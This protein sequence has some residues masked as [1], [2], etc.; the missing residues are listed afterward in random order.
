MDG[1]ILTGWRTE[2]KEYAQTFFDQHPRVPGREA[3]YAR[4]TIESYLKAL[5]PPSDDLSE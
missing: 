4:K 3:N 1:G 5:Y 2:S